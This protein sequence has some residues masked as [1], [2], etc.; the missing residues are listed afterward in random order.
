MEKVIL[1]GL[2]VESEMNHFYLT[3]DSPYEVVAFTVNQ[4]YI[5]EDTPVRIAHRPF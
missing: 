3:H 1:F 5:K 2:G 4:E